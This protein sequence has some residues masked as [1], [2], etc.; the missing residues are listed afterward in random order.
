MNFD[1]Q[2]H[3]PPDS[4]TAKSA[5]KGSLQDLSLD[6][7]DEIP[8]LPTQIHEDKMNTTTSNAT[9]PSAFLSNSSSTPLTSK[10]IPASTTV[11]SNSSSF[12][13]VNGSSCVQGQ[14]FD[15]GCSERCECGFDG[16]AICRPRCS[17]PFYRRGTLLN[18]PYCIEK[19]TEDPCCSIIACTQ[20]T[21]N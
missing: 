15:R 2:E 21:G 4:H 10:E 8:V 20:D 14:K 7:I 16:K 13:M 3:Q 18:D 9:T 17:M 11:P 19:P 5:E 6:D 12:V 1:M